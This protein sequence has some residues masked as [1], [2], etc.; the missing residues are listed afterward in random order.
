MNNVEP[1]LLHYKY[2]FD[3]DYPYFMKIDKNLISFTCDFGICILEF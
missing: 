2:I 3:L 1:M